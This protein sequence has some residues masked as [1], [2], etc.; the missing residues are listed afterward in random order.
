MNR[1]RIDSNIINKWN[2][3]TKLN[4]YDFTTII[5]PYYHLFYQLKIANIKK[6]IKEYK[7]IVI[8]TPFKNAQKYEDSYFIIID[9]WTTN[10]ELNSLTDYFTETIR[11][12]C[13]FGSYPSPFEYWQKNKQKMIYKLKNP[14]LASLRNQLFYE[15][16]LCNNFRIS[17]IL[18]ILK[19]FQCKKYLDIS[20]GWGDR[21]LASIF[22]NVDLYYSTDPN[23][24]LH[25]LYKKMITKFVK[26]ENRHKFIIHDI[27]FED[28]EIPKNIQFDLV[29]SSPPFF[30][31]EKYS[32][33]KNNSMTK[34]STEKEWC[35]NFLMKS[36]L[37]AY[38][39]LEKNGTMILYIHHSKL[40]DEKMQ[41]LH[42]MMK[43]KGQIYFYDNQLRGMHVW[44][45]VNY[46]VQRNNLT[47]DSASLRLSL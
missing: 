35:D 47:S 17:V 30:T 19:H 23:K 10:E 22:H 3:D 11:V 34:Y 6:I 2:E 45:K 29:F 38:H 44:Q 25:L 33:Y 1:N 12:Q 46:V 5:Y 41:L 24:D 14:T 18:P 28:L 9:K 31:L 21:L 37:K 13:K 8:R 4:K 39:Y 27:G 7:P 40:V 26:K 32:K 20:A 42:K 16:K 43:Y 36:I 15:T